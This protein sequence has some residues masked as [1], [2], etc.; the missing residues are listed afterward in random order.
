M[1]SVQEKYQQ[2][3]QR[4]H[5]ELV[6]EHLPLVYKMASRV[7]NVVGI[8]AFERGDLVS[9]GVLGLYKALERF[10][11]SRGA[12]FGSFAQPY[13]RGAMLDEVQ[14]L[15]QV[16]RAL[17][18]KHRRVREAFDVLAHQL[19]RTPTDAELAEYLGIDE[20]RLGEWLGDLEWTTVWSLDE[21]EQRGA[22]DAPDERIEMNPA[23]RLDRVE[24]AGRL[25][26]ALRLL[27]LREQQ[28]LYAYYQEELTL[29][30][31]AYVME[32]SE[33]QI[34][35]IHSKAILRLRGLLAE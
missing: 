5:D 23:Q 31:I 24:L 20:R 21:L 7:A 34:S 9:A 33:S 8:G 19:L 16:P 26:Q 13:V 15:R 1:N 6:R 35:R 22:W 10:D 28:V 18:D 25:A 2:W 11:S 29:K 14:K 4:K 12:T 17:R 3:E 27:D 30:E 32:L